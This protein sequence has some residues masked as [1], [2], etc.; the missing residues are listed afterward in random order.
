MH[1]SITLAAATVEA[2]GNK[3][4]AWTTT[5][6]S[7]SDITAGELNSTTPVFST[8]PPLF[9][10]TRRQARNDAV[11]RV[12]RLLRNGKGLAGVHRHART[13]S[14]SPPPAAVAAAEARSGTQRAGQT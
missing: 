7:T 13:T 5:I 6:T 9:P 4:K 11:V 14:C 2:L 8:E 12:A 3:T 10:M 1:S